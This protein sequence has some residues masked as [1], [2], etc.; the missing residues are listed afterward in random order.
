MGY[1]ALTGAHLAALPTLLQTGAE[2][3][4]FVWQATPYAP[5]AFAAAVVA[6]TFAVVMW[7]AGR[8]PGTLPLVTLA[9]GAAWWSSLYG[10]EL[11]SATLPGKLLFGRLSYLGIVVVPVSWFVFALAYTGRGA[12][13]TPTVVAALLAPAA[14]AAALPW[15]SSSTDVFWAATSLV[16]TESGTLLAVEY[17]PAFWLWSAYGYTLLAGGTVLLLWSV[18][19]DT[20][21]F[22]VQT[23][24]LLVGVAAPW[25]ANAT[26]LF[27]L[28]GPGTLDVTPV[29]FVVSALALGGGLRRYRF[30]DVH[31]AVREFARNELVERMAEPVIVLTAEGRIVDLN[32][33]ARR[34]LGVDADDVVGAPLDATAPELA[35]AI[36]HVDR[37]PVDFTTG[38]PPHHYEVRVSPL[39]EGHSGTVGQ[40]VTLRDVTER[41]RR[42]R[43]LAVLNRV[44]RHDL[45]NDIAA[46][47]ASAS[48]LAEEGDDIDRET[49]RTIIAEKAAEMEELV[50]TVR[51]VEQTLD[52]GGPTLDDVDIVRV[53][54]E[55]VDAA[56]HA[57]PD[58]VVETDHPPS[59]H[60][61][62][63]D[64][65]SSV[66]D[67]L[68]ENAVEH[69]DTDEPHVRVSVRRVVEN[70][71]PQVEVRV[72]DNGPG[73]PNLD[74]KILI[75]ADGARLEDASGL[76]LWLIN[77]IVTASGGE[78]RYEPNEPRGSVV[79]LRLPAA[80]GE[81]EDGDGGD[82]PDFDVEPAR[83]S[84]GA[85]SPG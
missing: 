22:R 19:F 61:R 45:R 42:E 20:R 84:A 16:V 24:L 39:R 65:V 63:T 31:P 59:E 27:R 1:G 51:E 40:L 17:G 36:E 56:R 23:A 77:W 74:R 37:D 82:R 47:R 83:Q 79:V 50:R 9:L 46:I 32:R 67:N 49:F 52:E 53:I 66:V 81:R 44:L 5:L 75:G 68:V 85:T 33:S 41:R 73:I 69:N 10:L 48:L 54:D 76:G 71:T 34:V 58:A 70:G 38:S 13:L 35:A 57:Y 60:V 62:S 2:R 15:T 7:R 30:L 26:Y 80:D 78:V 55:Q 28:F 12:R 43:Q 4:P 6:V 25:L 3:A 64:L 11:A 14:I 8:G 72:A 29:G 21:L 18:P